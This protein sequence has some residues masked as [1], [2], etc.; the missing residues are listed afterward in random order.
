MRFSNAAVL[1]FGLSGAACAMLEQRAAA[2]PDAASLDPERLQDL[3]EEHLEG[4]DPRKKR[5]HRSGCKSEG[6]RCS[7]DTQCCSR[8]CHHRT[9]AI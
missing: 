6:K 2:A 8:N 1:I 9:C 7:F 3:Y 5:P 4:R